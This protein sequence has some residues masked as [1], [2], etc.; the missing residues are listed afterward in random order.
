M[1]LSNV[2]NSIKEIDKLRKEI[3]RFLSKEISNN[4]LK[5]TI[6]TFSKLRFPGFK[7]FVT[8]SVWGAATQADITEF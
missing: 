2:Y 7:R 1:L 6:E 5:V 8:R 3:N 4:C